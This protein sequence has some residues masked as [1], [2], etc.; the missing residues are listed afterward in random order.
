MLLLDGR[1]LSSVGV[2]RYLQA[3]R[4]AFLMPVI[5]RGRK[6]HY[7]R[8]PSWDQRLPDLEEERLRHLHPA[9]RPQAAGPGVDL[10][11]V[12]LLPR[13]W[14]RHGKQRLVY[15]FWGL[16]PPSFDWVKEQ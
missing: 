11:Q 4:Q 6:L 9:R 10:R 5:G 16:M 12:P 8:G 7:L 3:A 15:A 14:R 13:P 2:I 1:E